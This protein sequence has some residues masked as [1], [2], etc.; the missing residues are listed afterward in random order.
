MH[1]GF[2]D[3]CLKKY[4]HAGP[5]NLLCDLFDYLPL[6]ALIEGNILMVHG[7]LSPDIKM[8]D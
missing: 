6:S 2:Y 4:G 3:E 7:G 1:Y 5:W 8:V